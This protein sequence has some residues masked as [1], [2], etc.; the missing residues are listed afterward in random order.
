MTNSSE[1]SWLVITDPDGDIK[2][3]TELGVWLG[4]SQPGKFPIDIAIGFEPGRTARTLL[5]VLV[6]LTAFCFVQITVNGN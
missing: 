6:H 2:L 3:V 5:D 4:V 1:P